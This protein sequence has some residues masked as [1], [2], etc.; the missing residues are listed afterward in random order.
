[1]DLSKVFDT[2]NDELLIANYDVLII[3]TNNEN[4]ENTSLKIL[5]SHL[6]SRW[7]RKKIKTP[8][9]SLT[10]SYKRNTT[11][12]STRTY[13]FQHILKRPFFSFLEKQLFVAMPITQ[14]HIHV[15]K[16]LINS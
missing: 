5:L 11:R 4:T 12:I 9:S 6:I 14:L 3:T 2:I 15:I 10:K 1:M 7:E 13:Y 8:F 16:I